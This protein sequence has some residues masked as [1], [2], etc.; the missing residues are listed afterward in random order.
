M[1][2]V[3]AAGAD[4]AQALSLM[5]AKAA[6]EELATGQIAA[7]QAAQTLLT[8]TIFYYLYVPVIIK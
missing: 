4:L 3:D 1:P 8:N 6:P 7:L 5:A 2:E